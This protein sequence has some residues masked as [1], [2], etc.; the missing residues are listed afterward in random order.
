MVV[1]SNG[2]DERAWLDADGHPHSEEM[3]LEEHFRRVDHDT[4]E[5]TM[6]LTDPKAYTK[7]WVAETKTLVLDPQMELQEDVCVPSD[8][9]KYRELIREPAAGVGSNK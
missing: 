1:E 7:P 3:T 5:L 2:F 6:T 9:Q 4:I 8:E